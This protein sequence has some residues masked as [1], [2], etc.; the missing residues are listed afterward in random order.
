MWLYRRISWT[1]LVSNVWVL[2]RMQK[3]KELLKTIK[4][5]KLEY[6][7]H[8][9]KN[10]NRYG[11][12]QLIIQGKIEGNRSPGRRRVSRLKNHRDWCSTT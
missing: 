3:E 8:I 2:Q 9:M 6:L 7:G 4:T 11:L 10:N 12:L 5:Q 1:D